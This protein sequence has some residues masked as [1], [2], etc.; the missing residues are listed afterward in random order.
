[1]LL[2]L[3]LP[4]L[5]SSSLSFDVCLCI[6][7]LYLSSTH[8]FAALDFFDKLF[9]RGKFF[10][11]FFFLH[12]CRLLFATTIFCTYTLRF[13]SS[14]HPST[15]CIDFSV[16]IVVF[17]SVPRLPPTHKNQFRKHIFFAFVMFA[18]KTIDLIV[19]KVSECV[20]RVARLKWL[21][22]MVILLLDYFVCSIC[23]QMQILRL[24]CNKFM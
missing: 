7:R 11:L 3:L 16:A 6:L 21:Y 10:F 19:G 8:C 13:S 23:W 17:F 1:M 12:C 22:E 14:V 4:L 2:L 9:L 20:N 24:K 15:V 5:L 18:Y